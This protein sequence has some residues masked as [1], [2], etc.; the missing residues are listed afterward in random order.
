MSI[1]VCW[2]TRVGMYWKSKGNL[3]APSGG[4]VHLDFLRQC[5][6]LAW[7]LPCRLSGWPVSPGIICL[8]VELR[9]HISMPGFL[10]GFYG[11]NVGSCAWKAN[12]WLMEAWSCRFKNYFSSSTIILYPQHT[13]TCI[14]HCIILGLFPRKSTNNFFLFTTQSSST[15]CLRTSD[16]KILKHPSNFSLFLS[17]L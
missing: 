11:W 10:C 1:H 17:A 5:L 9:V 7:I 15:Q 13:N 8:R 6:S 3:G 12:T 4:A 2:C 14:Q 16:I